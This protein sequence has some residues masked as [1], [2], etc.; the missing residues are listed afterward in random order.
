MHSHMSKLQQAYYCVCVCVCAR[1]RA[2][3]CTHEYFD[4]PFFPLTRGNVVAPTVL[5]LPKEEEEET[6]AFFAVDN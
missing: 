4:V 5:F 2:C 1:V 3:V 6:A